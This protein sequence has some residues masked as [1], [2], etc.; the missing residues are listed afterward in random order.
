MLHWWSWEIVFRCLGICDLHWRN[1]NQAAAVVHNRLEG[2]LT[3]PTVLF[4]LTDSY[5]HLQV[6]VSPPSPEVYLPSR[7]MWPFYLNK[8]TG[9]MPSQFF[10]NAAWFIYTGNETRILLGVLECSVNIWQKQKNL[11]VKLII[12]SLLWNPL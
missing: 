12:W 11:D 2:L 9:Y 8:S 5:R 1:C 4:R 6:S 7:L 10:N 3:V